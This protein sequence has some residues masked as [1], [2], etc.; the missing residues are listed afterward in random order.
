MT[1]W[2]WQK[3]ST[4]HQD[5]PINEEDKKI[6]FQIKYEPYMTS[7]APFLQKKETWTLEEI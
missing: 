1:G 6:P 5:Y 3:F 4:I 7:L 2:K